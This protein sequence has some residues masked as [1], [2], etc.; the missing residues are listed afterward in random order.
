MTFATLT[1]VYYDYLLHFSE[2]LDYIWKRCWSFG[3]ATYIF[4]RYGGMLYITCYLVLSI[5]HH[6]SDKTC[7]ILEIITNG[8]LYNTLT[9]VLQGV[10]AVRVCA[11]WNNQKKVVAPLLVLLVIAEVT[12]LGANISNLLPSTGFVFE[13]TVYLG[14]PVCVNTQQSNLPVWLEPLNSAVFLSLELVMMV[15]A[16]FKS[17]SHLRCLRGRIWDWNAH[18]LMTV[19]VR[20]NFF[21][22]L[23]VLV[24][25]ILTAIYSIVPFRSSYDQEL[26]VATGYDIVTTVAQYVRICLLGP[27]LILS[28]KRQTPGRS[29]TTS[30]QS[31][32]AF[33]VLRSEAETCTMA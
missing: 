30:R 33:A 24:N 4:L 23:W 16:L 32:I 3:K 9:L 21:Y 7:W 31:T 18:D 5:P 25:I 13:E 22:F 6:Q 19:L 17:Y 10:M 28:L 1:L 15:L 12:Y 11:L 20:D 8:F 2:E 26:R 29:P 27:W 14:L